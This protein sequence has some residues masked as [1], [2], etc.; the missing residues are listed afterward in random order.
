MDKWK[1]NSFM[2]V[3]RIRHV[4][5]T[6]PDKRYVLVRSNIRDFKLLNQIFGFQKGNE[7]LRCMKKLIMEH[8]RCFEVFDRLH[9]DQFIFMIE[10]ERYDEILFKRIAEACSELIDN[11]DFCMHFQLGIYEISDPDMEVLSMCD[12]AKL[13]IKSI[14]I[15]E[16]FSV[17]W[18]NESIMEERLYSK[19]IISE[20]DKA[21]KE[22]R[23]LVYLQPQA[24]TKGEIISAEA[25]ARWRLDD[26]TVL[27]PSHFID[28][29]EESELIWK[30]DLYMWDKAA[31]L[32]SQW[33]V[34]PEK[35]NLSLSVNISPKDL[36]YLDIADIMV[37]L[38]KKYD[39]PPSKMN[40]E[41]T[42]YSFVNSPDLYID[43][44]KRLHDAGFSI[45]I[46]DFGSGYSS[47]TLLK[48]IH[49]DVLKLD[50]GF[51]QGTE[52][53]IRTEIIIDSVIEMA[54]RLDMQVISEG[55]ETQEQAA[56]LKIN[57][58]DFFQG[59]YF[60]RPVP[61]EKFDTV[62]KAYNLERTNKKSIRP[63]SL[64][65]LVQENVMPNGVYTSSIA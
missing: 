1:L 54:K 53:L 26:G 23:F 11:A 40:I 13:A 41:I 59:F 42:E 44:I 55:V 8:E 9:V 30:L 28:I 35:K 57:G 43:L 48:N 65:D 51:L 20:F 38:V 17:A 50:M 18:Y 31:K 36:Y 49:A 63:K 60:S 15:D 46:D 29:L 33:K 2:F 25:L 5:C 3:E 4:L 19:K 45:E 24:N 21:L 16:P 12:R 47:L 62:L 6:H 7:I 27:S 14:K 61:L 39:I 32:L 10:K 37:G 58:C 52:D 56:F 22:E 34:D 64:R